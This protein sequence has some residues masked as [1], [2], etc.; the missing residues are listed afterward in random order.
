MIPLQ[1]RNIRSMKED[2]NYQNKH[3]N[4]I[5]EDMSFEEQQAQYNLQGN[6]I[7]LPATLIAS[8]AYWV[9]HRK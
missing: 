3:H 6:L 4:E 7:N 5:N 8:L 1:Y 2:N 9:V